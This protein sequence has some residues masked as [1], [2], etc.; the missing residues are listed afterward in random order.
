[1][2]LGLV[3]YMWG[4]DWDLP[5]VLKNCRETGFTGVELAADTSMALSQ[6][7]VKQHAARW[8]NVLK[9]VA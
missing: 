6:V 1:M 5:T 7:S 9:T 3:T 8:R 2:Q 4:T